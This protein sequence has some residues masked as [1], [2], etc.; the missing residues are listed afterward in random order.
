MLRVLGPHRLMIVMM[1]F[2]AASLNHV[3]VSADA[4]PTSEITD[5]KR[6][7]IDKAALH[8]AVRDSSTAEV[9]SKTINRL[10]VLQQVF[11]RSIGWL[12][13]QTP[14]PTDE[15]I[16]WAGAVHNA[17]VQQSQVLETPKSVHKVF[18]KLIATL[19]DRMKRK[20]LRFTLTILDSQEA[21]IFT[22]GA[23]FIHVTNSCL[24]AFI[25]DGELSD[26]ALALALAREIG[27]NCRGHCR[28]AWKLL[29]LQAEMKAGGH[30]PKQIALLGQFAARSIKGKGGETR[31]AYS[32][33]QIQQADLFAMH[34]CR[35]A[36]NDTNRCL[37]SFRFDAAKDSELTRLR[38]LLWERSGHVASE[39][40]GLFEFRP[41]D[42]TLSK[43]KAHPLGDNESAVVFLHGM[44]SNLQLQIKTLQGLASYGG[45][46]LRVFGFEYPN[47]QSLARSGI[48][49]KQEIERV[50]QDG[51]RVDFVCHSAGGLVFR[52]YAEIDSGKFRKAVFLGTPHGGSD[53]AKLQPILEAKKLLDDLKLGIPAGPEGAFMD[54]SGQIGFDLQPN[55]LFLQYLN[56]KSAIEL[57]NR[58][59][60]IRGRAVK[61]RYAALMGIG[62]AALRKY[63]RNELSQSDTS[64]LLRECGFVWIGRL[65]TPREF[66]IGDFAV[67]L[68]SAALKGVNE[69]MTFQL[70]HRELA[71]DAESIRAVVGFF[72]K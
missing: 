46:Q 59:M 62:S 53:L 39:E 8:V 64:E 54:G 41:E 66:L 34:L 44:E 1:T 17:I 30:D 3:P 19:P 50:F 26:D 56:Q 29:W 21:E 10:V 28:S 9:G 20:P 69:T 35:N 45:E 27:H 22:I 51:N 48:F 47:D 49:L 63:L 65:H 33:K 6:S 40:F 43:A 42:G 71:D 13:N 52:Y 61:R 24:K 67:T 14:M 38:Q 31:L 70:N 18:D 4:K 57:R 37:D 68:R 58:Y 15:E 16:K 55:S 36:G 25:D 2:A 5:A 7:E 72:G 11:G 23:G 32:E 12:V 60:V